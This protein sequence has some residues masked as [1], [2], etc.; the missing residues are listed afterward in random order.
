[1]ITTPMTTYFELLREEDV[2]ELASRARI[3][4]H[5][6]TGAEVL[7]LENEDENKV[8]GI[9]FRTPP[10]DST[11]VAHILEHSVL[12]GSRKYPLK[13]PFVELIKGS[14]KTFLN[15]FTFPD[16]TCYPVASQN[17]NDFYNL[18]DVYLDSVFHPRLTPQIF[19]QEGWHYELES[20]GDPLVYRGIVFNEMKGAYGSPDN[21][22]YRYSQQALF[23]DNAY[24]VDS[25]G[26]PRSIPDL[27]YEQLKAFHEAYY[28]PSNA[29]IF[30]YGD[31]DPETRLRIINEYL[32]EFA[33][34]EIDSSVALQEPYTSPHRVEHTYRVDQDDPEQQKNQMTV[35]WLLNDTTD[36]SSVLAL[37][38]LEHILIGSPGS[39]LRKALLDSG[40]GETLTGGGYHD[41][42]RQGYFS[43]GMKGIKYADVDAIEELILQTLNDLA[44]NGI[45]RATIGAAINTIEFRLRE[46]NTGS[47][48][49]GLI[50]M[51]RSL[52]SW[53]HESDPLA[54]LAFEKPLSGIKTKIAEGAP[55]FEN[56]IRELFLNNLH[57]ATV[58]LRPDPEQ[59]QRET[60]AEKA[61]LAAA[62][63]ELSEAQ[64]QALIEQ[65]EELKAMQ[66]RPDPP[67]ALATIPSLDLD[68]LERENKTIPLELGEQQGVRV[69]YH[70]LPTSGIIY[71]D[72]GL[73]LHTL[74]QELLPYAA[75]LGQTLLELN[76]EKEDYVKLSQ[77]IG[78]RTG[79]IRISDMV[80]AVHGT[81]ESQ[82]WLMLRGKANPAQGAELLA[83]LRDI[84]LTV[85]LDDRERFR[86][87][88][89]K[90]RA[91]R[92]TAI[93]P[94]GHGFVNLRL[95]AC[96]NEADW[97]DEQMNGISYLFFL[98]QMLKDIEED[99]PGVLARLEQVRHTLVSRSAMICNVTVDSDNW[100]RFAPQLDEFLG[101]MP[102]PAAE[103]VAWAPDYSSGFEGLIIPS[104]VNY[105]GKGTNLYQSGYTYHGSAAVALKYLRTSHLWERIRMQGGAY[106]AFC[107]FGRHS[108]VMR[109]LSYR[110][111]NLT[112][113]L[114][115]YDEAGAFLRGAPLDETAVTRSIIGTIGE[116]D[117]YQ[118]PD[119]KG[120]TSLT[121]YLRNVSEEERQRIREEV[122][123][124]TAEHIRA[125]ADVLDYVRDHGTVMVLGSR[126]AISAA[127]TSFEQAGQR[128]LRPVDVL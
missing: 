21:L 101:S 83:I 10:T 127:N 85:Q 66:V 81:P 49:R 43:I 69:L 78:R 118:L 79:G 27:T 72:V 107:S 33:P 47:M 58:V 102:A 34:L 119:A 41:D 39:P 29:R 53:L 57:R 62:R 52:T 67:E 91:N 45:E 2:P 115:A 121:R 6:R 103:R 82:A 93:V 112:N 110:D 97:A 70:D 32:K 16:K 5:L 120:Y 9:T 19:A 14:L 23:P 24:G 8:F 61:R 113:T 95:S 37:S 20:P 22:L 30:F 25:G 77:R 96:F 108:G 1:M 126:D 42:L 128:T 73:D 86:Q 87:L 31:D 74:P 26:D 68:D 60:A 90:A 114:N 3:Y 56:L 84:L 44:T 7:S 35:N 75:L 36:T 59:G 89:L 71:L 18:I 40:L 51:I 64:I 46:N 116:M 38:I 28:H 111:P 104:Q 99:W 17:T 55:F 11:G 123:G 124:T 76:T 50:A 100:S 117:A 65:T 122:L 12:C 106:G 54:P 88:V 125:F 105:V 80:A 63:A 4:R 98:R 13:E 109:Y 48:P 15:A 92:E 94:R